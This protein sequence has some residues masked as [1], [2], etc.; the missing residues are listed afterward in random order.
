MPQTSPAATRASIAGWCLYDWAN[1]PF[2]AIILTFVIPAYFASAI[3]SD[4]AAAQAEWGFMVGTA[5]FVVAVLSPI[6]GAV[7]D[8]TGRRKAWIAFCAAVMIVATGLLWWGKPG[9]ESAAWILWWSGVGLVAFELGLVFYN[10]LLPGLGPRDRLGRISGTAWATGYMG[11][12]ACL[13]LA[14]FG[15]VLA[16]PPPLGL[17]PQQGEHVRITGPLVAIWM[18][19]FCLPLFLWTRD[20]P[21]GRMTV[22]AAIRTGLGKL[23]RDLSG[24]LADPERRVVGRYLVARM[25]YTDGINTVFA[26]GGIYAAAV[27]G[28]TVSEVVQFAILINITAGIGAFVFGRVDDRLG[29]K[30]TILIGLVAIVVLSTCM[31]FISTQVLFFAVGAV[32]GIF[33]GPVQSA[34]RSLM[35]RLVPV[36]EEAEAFGLYALSG[37]VTAFVGPWLVGVVTL[38]TDSERWGLATVIPFL[39]VGA[40][41]LLRVPDPSR[42]T[43]A[44]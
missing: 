23:Y 6:L 5:S 44:T 2:A 21:A 36:G 42:G 41:L 22:P 16:D 27:I 31:L 43:S 19:L 4:D 20:V 15:I 33:F 9:P 26:F 39:I 34:S 17:D 35:A 28:M 38:A 24:M 8:R 11:G 14:L 1:S 32:L 7:A 3:L 40:L 30:P 37:K 25:V 18:G 12:M 13:A 29:A 10:A